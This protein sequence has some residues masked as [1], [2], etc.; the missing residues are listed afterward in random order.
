MH[1]KALISNLLHHS[2]FLSR[3][4]TFKCK[5]SSL[6]C[7]FCSVETWYMVKRIKQ[8]ALKLRTNMLNQ[9]RHQ[10]L[11]AILLIEKFATLA[12]VLLPI[13]LP[14]A[15]IKYCI[16]I[17][18][19]GVIYRTTPIF[20]GTILSWISWFDFWSRNLACSCWAWLRPVQRSER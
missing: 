4:L 17:L 13:A 5:I 6:D 2:Y 8:I 1:W 7:I 18:S 16:V 3:P 14:L 19:Q 10:T 15:T 12:T 9:E 11:K 20:R